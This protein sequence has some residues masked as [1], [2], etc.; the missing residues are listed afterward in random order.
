MSCRLTHLHVDALFAT[1]PSDLLTRSSSPMT[2]AE[3]DCELRP[4]WRFRPLCVATAGEIRLAGMLIGLGSRR[5]SA[6]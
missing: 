5:R 4:W 6:S 1:W 3:P 2:Y